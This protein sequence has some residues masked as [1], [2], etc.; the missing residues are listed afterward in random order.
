MTNTIDEVIALANAQADIARGVARD[1]NDM[2]RPSIT[3][4]QIAH[5]LAAY[6]RDDPACTINDDQIRAAALQIASHPAIRASIR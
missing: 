6:L 2:R 5:R 4:D 1:L 3:I